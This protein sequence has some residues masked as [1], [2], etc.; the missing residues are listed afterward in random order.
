MGRT[1]FVAPVAAAAILSCSAG[2]VLLAVLP[3]AAQ[4]QPLTSAERERVD[5]AVEGMLARG[6]PSASV[7][8]VRGGE[9][10]FAKAYGLRQLSPPQP[11]TPETRYDIGSVSKQFTATLALQLAE[12]GRLS[13]DDPVGRH[14]P[15]LAVGPAVSVREALAQ[16]AGYPNYW[17]VDY[18]PG[19]VRAPTTPD[20]ILVNWA[21]RPLAF[22]PGSDWRYSNTNY[23]VGARV[24]ETAGGRP[25][26][27]ML[28]TRIFAPLAMTTAAG[29]DALASADDAVG[30]RRVAVAA[31]RPSTPVGPGWSFGA[32]GLVMSAGDL[33]RWDIAVIERRLLSVDSYRLQ[34]TDVALPSGQTTGYGLGVYVRRVGEHRVIAHNGLAPGFQAEN[35]I[36]PDD[37]AAIVVLV[38]AGDGYA[39]PAVVI[40]DDLAR[41]VLPDLPDPT[42]EKRSRPT[43][44]TRNA[45]L[46]SGRVDGARLTADAVADLT[47]SV[48]DY[49]TSLSPL[50]EPSSF[51][52]L[53]RFANDG[54][55]VSIHEARWRDRRLLVT[56]YRDASGKVAEFRVIQPDW[57]DPF[58]P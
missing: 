52:L 14:L 19:Y 54:W 50:G 30:Y 44:E 46:R 32:G 40:G 29:P 24:V 41:I 28:R 26:A 27:E 1:G 5:R 49:Q 17:T 20:N 3:A 58:L 33:A 10:V 4:A 21:T 48:A 51:L 55:D 8:I 56:M 25:F 57:P 45:E 7:A 12:E 31:P 18:V 9:V 6:V 2:V 38:N 47:P 53:D 43:P 11:A 36:Y 23:T 13:L 39:A 35:R 42:P 22:T 34:Q 37:R 16:T 15:A